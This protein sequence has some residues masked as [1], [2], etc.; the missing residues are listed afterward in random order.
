MKNNIGKA[1]KGNPNNGG[2]NSNSNRSL[3][4]VNNNNNSKMKKNRNRLQAFANA[5][6]KTDGYNPALISR[7]IGSSSSSSSEST[8]QS[9]PTERLYTQAEVDAIMASERSRLQKKLR[10]IEKNKQAAIYEALLRAGITVTLP[11]PSQSRDE[12]PR[13]DDKDD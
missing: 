7:K 10:A 9:R 11:W 2:I 12:E 13:D 6:T 1:S 8:A 5:K 3:A 4:P